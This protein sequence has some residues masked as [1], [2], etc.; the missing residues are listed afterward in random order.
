ME[1]TEK[2]ADYFQYELTPLSTSLF[3]DSFKRK[4]KKLLL[5]TYLTTFSNRN[6]K[7]K[8]KV[9]RFSHLVYKVPLYGKFGM[10]RRGK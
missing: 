5:A 9:Q 4:S 7:R 3:K 10:E 2:I 6:N 1:R 8:R